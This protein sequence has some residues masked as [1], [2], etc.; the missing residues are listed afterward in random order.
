[1]MTDGL[2]SKSNEELIELFENAGFN[3]DDAVGVCVNISRI[4]SEE[5]EDWAY[6]IE[7]IY[8]AFGYN[9]AFASVALAPLLSP[10]NCKNVV[11]HLS[12]N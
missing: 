1:M 12:K 7:K 3:V 10:V 8:K 2:L 9:S 4:P 5:K 6:E 11:Y